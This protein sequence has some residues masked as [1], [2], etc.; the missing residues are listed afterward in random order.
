MTSYAATR[1]TGH[2]HQPNHIHSEPEDTSFY[3]DEYSPEPEPEL[4]EE[5]EALKR[6]S[7]ELVQYLI[8]KYLEAK[9]GERIAREARARDARGR[10]GRR[11]GLVPPTLMQ[12]H[13]NY[14]MHFPVAQAS[15]SAK[16]SASQLAL[17]PLY[18]ALLRAHRSLPKDMRGLGD[19]YVKSEFRLHKDTTNPLHILGFQTQWMSYLRTI[20]A[21]AKEEG[22]VRGEKLGGVL[23][24]M[25]GE[26]V[27]QIWEVRR[28]VEEVWS[29]GEKNG[30]QGGGKE[31]QGKE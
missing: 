10:E 29:V 14:D 26:Q 11:E 28:V 3:H 16:S 22:G 4:D 23:G 17:I 20:Q 21:Q 18:R 9:E 19:S 30:E 2:P 25:S 1:S 5:Q 15:A 7:R 27:G 24:K 13:T 12:S 31:G 8:G 6:Y